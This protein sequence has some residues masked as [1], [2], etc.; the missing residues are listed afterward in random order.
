M[1][2]L[3]W[4]RTLF[5]WGTNPFRTSEEHFSTGDKRVENARSHFRSTHARTH[6]HTHTHT[7][8][9]THVVTSN[10]Q[11]ELPSR[12]L[13]TG[14]QLRKWAVAITLS[15]THLRVCYTYNTNMGQNTGEQCVCV[16]VSFSY[17]MPAWWGTLF[18][19]SYLGIIQWSLAKMTG[20]S[21][22]F[23]W[24]QAYALLIFCGGLLGE[25]WTA[26]KPAV[27]SNFLSNVPGR[28]WC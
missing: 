26:I 4:R 25:A 23:V 11:T 8:T 5:V 14:I 10:F 13:L 9:A 22:K 16:C 27:W 24:S 1:C 17:W 7:H 15:R 20:I 18:W 2:L 12:L 6:T 3:C 21:I 19:V 28:A